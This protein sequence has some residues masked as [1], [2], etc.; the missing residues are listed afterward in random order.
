[1]PTIAEREARLV[2][3]LRAH[4][5]LHRVVPS[6]QRFSEARR[7]DLT[8]TPEIRVLLEGIRDDSTLRWLLQF[9][10]GNLGLAAVRRIGATGI[11]TSATALR[12]AIANDDEGRIYRAAGGR[13]AR[14]DEATDLWEEI[15]EEASTPS[16]RTPQ[17]LFATITEYAFSAQTYEPGTSDFGALDQFGVIAEPGDFMMISDA[18][19]FQFLGRVV[20]STPSLLTEFSLKRTMVTPAFVIL[21][22]GV[23]AAD[24][25]GETTI[26][27]MGDFEST[28]FS[29]A[30]FRR[31]KL[32]A[33]H[34]ELLRVEFTHIPQP[35][36]EDWRGFLRAHSSRPSFVFIRS[37]LSIVEAS[38][39]SVE[40]RAPAAGQ[41]GS[42]TLN[43]LTGPIVNIASFTE[44]PP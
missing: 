15:I 8:D 37:D 28:A 19:G 34:R 38:P 39:V 24:A 18:G 33:P 41:A 1:M 13:L 23:I 9:A 7:T 32:T 40:S 21:S 25:G 42:L 30:G 4:F 10:E 14:R 5:P 2:T 31:K 36:I 11:I 44:F 35:A 17:A 20:Q 29:L 3:F 6:L 16:S 43:L 22:D 26:T 12:E 27:N